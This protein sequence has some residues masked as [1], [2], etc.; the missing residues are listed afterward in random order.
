MD[1]LITVDD[2]KG[3]Y[4][5]SPDAN[6]NA[7]ILLFI[8]EYQEKYLRYFFG[9]KVYVDF[10]SKY[11][12]NTPEIYT[13]LINGTDVFRANDKWMKFDGF[14]KMLI[15]FIY[16][17]FMRENLSK[18]TPLGLVT[19]DISNSKLNAPID[20]CIQAWNNAVNI[21]ET[22]LCYCYNKISDYPYFD[23]EILNHINVWGI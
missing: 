20:E 3:L 23:P 13:K 7:D 18:S 8:A 16:F 14:K 10:V 12:D 11:G 2:F 6:N 5:I 22:G 19:P 4:N 21:Y 1:A 9:E 17:H 15:P